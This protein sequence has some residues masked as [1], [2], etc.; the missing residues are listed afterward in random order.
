MSAVKKS[1]ASKAK[2]AEIKTGGKNPVKI[3]DTTFRDAHQSSF[4][5]R[6]RM[7]DMEP[8]A[9]EMS[10]VTHRRVATESTDLENS[11]VCI[12]QTVT[13][14]RPRRIYSALTKPAG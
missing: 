12:G 13:K 8:V 11:S 10:L 3:C 2:K 9:A 5:T 4:A 7:E 14:L 1:S 6:M